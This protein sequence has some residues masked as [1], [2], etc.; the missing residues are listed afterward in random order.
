VDYFR[1]VQTKDIKYKP[2]IAPTDQPPIWLN[3]EIM[4][5]YK[6]ELQKYY[7]DATKYKTYLEQLGIAYPT[8]RE[9]MKPKMDE[10]S[11]ARMSVT[12]ANRSTSV[13][14]SSPHVHASAAH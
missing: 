2:F 5:R 4:A 14:C 8:T 7:Y 10:S 11:R 9:T 13:S 12:G 3:A 1:D 6:P